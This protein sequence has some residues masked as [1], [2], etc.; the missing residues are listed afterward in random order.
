MSQAPEV[1]KE[2][3][4][5]PSR[6][7]EKPS[8]DHIASGKTGMSAQVLEVQNF[9]TRIFCLSLTFPYLNGTWFRTE[10]NEAL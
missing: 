3:F 5:D 7:S 10:K 9:S 1:G 2:N 4:L 6:E 8:Q